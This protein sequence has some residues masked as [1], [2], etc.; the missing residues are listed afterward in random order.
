VVN[1]GSLSM[2][3]PK[4][5]ETSTPILTI[6]NGNPNILKNS[7]SGVI[8]EN[9][10]IPKPK[11]ITGHGFMEGTSGSVKDLIKFYKLDED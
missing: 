7:V 10:D 11:F 1:Q 8:L 6:Y 9:P 2:S 5:L 4:L 3:L